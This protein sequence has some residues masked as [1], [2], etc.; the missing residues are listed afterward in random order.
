MT[1]PSSH[2]SESIIV[3][4]PTFIFMPSSCQYFQAE[5]LSAQPFLLCSAPNNI[6]LSFFAFPHH[7]SSHCN[8]SR[9]LT[10]T[11]MPPTSTVLPHLFSLVA[12]YQANNF[13]VVEELVDIIF[14]KYHSIENLNKKSESLIEYFWIY[15]RKFQLFKLQLRI[16]KK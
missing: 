12:S 7:S 5:D 1:K 16:F 8:N 6:H 11:Y 13:R 4:S 15:Q 2:T 14:K 3:T 10:T 9:T